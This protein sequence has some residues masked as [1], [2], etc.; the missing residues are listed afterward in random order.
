[1]Y[2]FFLLTESLGTH[3]LGQWKTSFFSAT[4]LFNVCSQMIQCEH[5]H[6]EPRLH[7]D[8]ARPQ[9]HFKIDADQP[10]NDCVLWF[11]KPVSDMQVWLSSNHQVLLMHLFQFHCI[12]RILQDT[13]IQQFKVS[14][15]QAQAMPVPVLNQLFMFSMFN[16]HA[17][18]T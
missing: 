7:V 8:P 13:F 17:H 2:F 11:P 5:I 15:Q 14:M 3:L 4:G 12:S 10:S 16:E 9:K 1:M 6:F 18:A